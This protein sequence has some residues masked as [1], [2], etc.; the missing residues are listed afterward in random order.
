MNENSAQTLPIMLL[1]VDDHAIVRSGIR[2]FL[3]TQ[4]DMQVVGEAASGEEAV[5]L[6]EKLVPDVVLMDLLMDGMDGIEATWRIRRI[7][8]RS[9]IVV[10]TSHHEDAHIFPAIKAGALSYVLKNIKPAELADVIRAAARGEAVL[11]PRVARRLVQEL[12]RGR[13]DTVNPF[14]ELSERE[15]EVLL[16]I[17]EGMSNGEIAEKLYLSERTV[18]GHVTNILN[19]LHLQDRT[20]AAVYAWREGMVRKRGDGI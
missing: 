1:I 5:T 4:T 11:N 8:P 12:Q 10:L 2:A 19:K 3:E 18:K 15:Q 7:S 9:Q 14:T 13:S 20:Q 17:A 6:A 16:L